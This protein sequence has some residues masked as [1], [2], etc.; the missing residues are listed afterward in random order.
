MKTIKQLA[1]D[2]GVSKQYIHKLIRDLKPSIK[3]T[4][5][6]NKLLI[7]ELSE[8]T[9]LKHFYGRSTTKNDNQFKN[10]NNNQFSI[11]RILKEQID[12]KDNQIDELQKL[13]KELTKLLDQQQKLQLLLTQEKQQLQLKL[14][15]TK[16]KKSLFWWLKGKVD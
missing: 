8:N 11:N 6:G 7:D 5:S 12:L 10:K 1:D 2:L 3:L 14:N 13:N 9:I 15:A 4:T 16:N